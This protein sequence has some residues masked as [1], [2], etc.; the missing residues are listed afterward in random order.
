MR[1]SGTAKNVTY[2]KLCDFAD[3]LPR[4]SNWRSFTTGRQVKE[5]KAQMSLVVKKK[6]VLTLPSPIRLASPTPTRCVQLA[7]PPT[8]SPW[9]RQVTTT[10]RGFNV[11]RPSHFLGVLLDRPPSLASISPPYPFPSPPFLWV[12]HVTIIYRGLNV[13]SLSSE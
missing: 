10:H 6:N 1:H 2:S 5:L 13:N 9:V 7:F 12:A 4:I 3:V 11:H 8:P